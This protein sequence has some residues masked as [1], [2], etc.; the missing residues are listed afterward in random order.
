M[1]YFT[2]IRRVSAN[3]KSFVYCV[4]IRVGDDNDW[5]TVWNRFLRTDLHTEQEL[6]LNALG[7]TKN[8][9]LIDKWVLR[10][11]LRK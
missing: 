4:G 1:M 7:C 9:Q 5:H 2:Y 6:L 11:K 8:P 3:L 10:I